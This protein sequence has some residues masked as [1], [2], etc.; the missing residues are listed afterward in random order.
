MR[1]Q[2]LALATTLTLLSSSGLVT[3]ASYAQKGVT[4]QPSSS[5]AV[6]RI[7]QDG[8]DGYCALARRF[9]DDVILTLAKNDKN[10]ASLALDFAQ[11]GFD[12]ARNYN[13]VIDPGA[14]AQRRF[15]I[16]PSSSRAFVMR[17]GDDKAFMSA[18]L[19]TGYL[20]VEMDSESF[21]FNLAD[22]DD[23]QSQL[24]AC[25]VDA[26]MPAAGD[27]T[28]AKSGSLSVASTA[29]PR[30]LDALRAEQGRLEQRLSVLERE[31][32]SLRL[33]KAA[34]E[35]SA[36]NMTP[37]PVVAEPLPVIQPDTKMMDGLREQIRSLKEENASLKS[38]AEQSDSH[39]NAAMD[40]STNGVKD[41][42]L[43]A[44]ARENE[45]LKTL[46]KDQE[47]TD[48]LKQQLKDLTQQIT[49]L[50]KDNMEL[51]GKLASAS[52]SHETLTELERQLSSLKA[53]NESMKAL[54]DVKD[55]TQ[56]NS[57]SLQD[58]I[59]L[60]ND[61]NQTLLSQIASLSLEKEDAIAQMHGFQKQAKLAQSLSAENSDQGLLEQMRQQLQAAEESNVEELAEKER[62]I[63]DLQ[64]ELEALAESSHS[65]ES[66]IQGADNTTLEYQAQLNALEQENARLVTEM[67]SL[68][69]G[70]EVLRS[71]KE[72]VRTL[73]LEKGGLETAL[74][75]ATDKVATIQNAIQTVQSDQSEIETLKRR[76]AS[77]E[78]SVV[79][80][81]DQN[82]ALL[83][84]NAALKSGAES[85]SV[86]Y[87]A[88]EQEL[89]DLKTENLTLKQSMEAMLGENSNSQE[90]M[91]ALLS[92]NEGLREAAARHADQM[93]NLERV[94]ADFEKLRAEHASLLITLE[95]LKS[96]NALSLSEGQG[97]LESKEAEI[98]ALQS[99]V[100]NL[101]DENEVLKLAS[102]EMGTDQ[103][104]L[105]NEIETLNSRINELSAENESVNDLL[106]TARA[107]LEA[108]DPAINERIAALE[109]ENARLAEK[110]EERDA[111]YEKLA[112]EMKEQKKLEKLVSAP[113]DLFSGD[114]AEAM[115]IKSLILNQEMENMR[116][117]QKRGNTSPLLH[118]ASLD[119]SQSVVR[120]ELNDSDSIETA[121]AESVSGIEPAAG[122]QNGAQ[123]ED[124]QAVVQK[125]IEQ[126]TSEPQTI[127]TPEMPEESSEAGFEALQEEGGTVLN[128]AQM[129]EQMLKQE[130]SAH[131]PPEIEIRNNVEDAA[132]SMPSRY[133][134]AGETPIQKGYVYAPSI[135]IEE[136]LGAAGIVI[137][138]N[139]S[140]VEKFSGR[141][142]VAYQWQTADNVFGSAHQMP[143][144]NMDEFDAKVRDYLSMT[145]Q[146]CS[147]DFAIVPA[148]TEQFGQTR[149]DGYEIACVGAGVNSSASVAFFN[150][151]GTFTILAHEA[152]TEAMETAMAARDKVVQ[153]IAKS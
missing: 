121:M 57:A 86:S 47:S 129:H 15:T 144:A 50:E 71:L 152:P 42:S 94:N 64:K 137:P 127:D 70:N 132:D 108:K 81:E 5:W 54:K 48:D 83:E 63:A 72:R 18:L 112:R 149:V 20:R 101:R 29:E 51:S 16:R 62:Q 39:Q 53:E 6:K 128:E 120:R 55:A 21:H 98:Q 33:Q 122:E 91:A 74:A 92:E 107:E 133:E 46:V 131:T 12:P 102:V 67:A 13:I 24:D 8:S 106:E 119:A 35:E 58:E 11:S 61:R 45:R 138:E 82:R 1:I 68:Q 136:I 90:E 103:D 69:Q 89:A 10:E 85:Q 2:S 100:K 116:R 41:I 40:S 97:T 130:L 110:L 87:S 44:L 75:E 93:E 111:A 135:Q 95:N 7:N 79:N 22:I 117:A 9:K 124:V 140:V 114:E 56:S 148:M 134:S 30:A 25:L 23:G 125:V 139:I 26:V 123:N 38:M 14:G 49:S 109:A 151:D 66:S 126:G 17:V 73:E 84:D 52:Q 150:V 147:G 3:T 145:E 142:R 104:T 36:A 153:S 96:E 143:I 99:E 76:I 31:N 27:E 65:S 78:T 59:R 88:L 115:R 4:L 28:G 32:E 34:A 141:D 113:A 118:N 19:K 105:T 43:I 77:L 37:A 80:A 146:R 60:L